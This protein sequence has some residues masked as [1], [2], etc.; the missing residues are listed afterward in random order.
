M[1]RNANLLVT[2][3]NLALRWRVSSCLIPTETATMMM[4][5]RTWIAYI[6]AAQTSSQTRC[7]YSSA[8]ISGYKSIPSKTFHRRAPP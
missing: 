7:L 6:S 4:R 8:S 2:T 5:C 3:P 1:I